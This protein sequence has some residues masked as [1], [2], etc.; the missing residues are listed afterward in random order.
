MTVHL[1][2]PV[3][4][5]TLAAA[6]EAAY[7]DHRT[8][9]AIHTPSEVWSYE[10]LAENAHAVAAAIH[11]T[12]RQSPAVHAAGGTPGRAPVVAVV[13]ERSPEFVA[14]VLG[15]LAAGAA[16]LPLDPA[17][18][19]AYLH[20]VL[21]EARPALVITSPARARRLQAATDAPVRTYPDLISR[22]GLRP[23]PG[24]GPGSEAA[25]SNPAYVIHTSGSTG[26]PKGVVVPHAALLNST[27]A[28]T[29]RYGAAGRV[30]LLHSPAFDLTTGILFWTLLT[31]GTLII[32]PARLAD[33]A[34]TVDL[35]HRHGVT[36]LIYPASLY[37]VLL[38]RAADRPLTTLQAVGIGSERW[39]PALIGRHAAV[40]P[41]ASL[42]NEY[43][44]T[45]ATV[46]SSYGLLYDAATG[47]QA[48]MSIGRPVRNT[49]YLIL[50]PDG[51]PSTA[52]GTGTGELG[53]TGANLA[54]G[55]LDQPEL[56]RQRFVTI[57]AD[58][59]Y[60]TG[61]IVEQDPDGNFVFLHRADR[62]IQVGGHR[63]EP[64]HVETVLMSHPAVL[65]AHVTTR[66]PRSPDT[67]STVLT[68][69]VVPRPGT[70]SQRAVDGQ[71]A[72]APDG[73]GSF[74]DDCDSYLRDRL[75][76]YLVP[77]T[78]VVLADLPRTPAG[79][80]DSGALPDPAGRA[81]E[82]DPGDGTGGGTYP[83]QQHLASL[84]ADILGL[85]HIP[86]DRSL[87]ALGANS[88][89]L[90]RLA[91]AITTNLGVDVA[92]S[93][94]FTA[95]TITQIAD[96]VRDAAPAAELLPPA[97]TTAPG[98]RIPLS[99]QQQQ[100]WVLSQLAPD[101]L[102]YNTQFSLELDGPL[103]VDALQEALTRIV[104]RHEILRTTFH[105]DPGGGAGG[106]VQIVH[107]PWPG[108]RRGRGPHRGSTNRPATRNSPT[109]CGP[110]SPPG[111]TWGGCRWS[112]GTC[113]ASHRRGGGCCRSSITSRTTGG[114][115][116]C[117]WASCGTPTPRS[118]PAASRRCQTCS[119]STGTSPPGTGPGAAPP[120]SPARSA[121]GRHTW[122]AA[123]PTGRRS[124]RT[125]PGR[126]P[127]PSAGTG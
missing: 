80:I 34:A 89:A 84:A 4:L 75:P 105:D 27:A 65:Q 67:E 85:A 122:R 100:I 115:R 21:G 7:R 47:E 112:A 86:A 78:Y 70:G 120:P 31:G 90:I 63:V 96:L 12:A 29:D 99:G 18:P 126:R 102:A 123:R 93:A 117:S 25:P 81:A 28:R 83:L 95:R 66:V 52:P 91:A 16:Y 69:Y 124:P 43:G 39:S 40:L 53:V 42:V 79:K 24:P 51:H 97:D 44:P 98:A 88:L 61:D 37:G 30:L 32:D 82:P 3:D 13:L 103:D 127:G 77:S 62:Q 74:A 59:V 64:G 76:A 109:G 72:T 121:T 106:A 41:G 33:V 5:P 110:R 108:A 118:S 10:D 104:A 58:R 20:Q 107:D 55:Y 101:A 46:C 48:P 19:D 54:L 60:R 23:E 17:A 57:G 8:T 22:P 116:S 6:L 119:R 73:A 15:V 92:I 14:T 50:D 35:V 49:G 94:L 56:T 2:A 1:Q 36:H 87:P 113:S 11:A 114:R 111:S 26:T 38:D 71:P 9:P 68:A 125:G 45:E